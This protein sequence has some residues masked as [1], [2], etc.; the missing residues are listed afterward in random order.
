MGYDWTT[1]YEWVNGARKKRTNERN[2]KLRENERK[3]VGRRVCRLGVKT[4]APSSS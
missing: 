1:E 3:M 2:I 4:V